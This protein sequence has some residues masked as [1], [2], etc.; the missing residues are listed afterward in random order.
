MEK[1]TVKELRMIC[2]R[3]E[4]PYNGLKMELIDRVT[5]YICKQKI[6]ED[7]EC[8]APDLEPVATRTTVHGKLKSFLKNTMWRLSSFDPNANE[9]MFSRMRKSASLLAILLGVFG[10]MHSLMQIYLYYTSETIP[11]NIDLPI[12]WW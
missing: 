5:D 4:L 7:D 8:S 3:L 2:R 11:L 12:T 9:S 1:L 10:G 6:Y